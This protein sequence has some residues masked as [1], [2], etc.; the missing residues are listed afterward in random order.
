M[1]NFISNQMVSLVFTMEFKKVDKGKKPKFWSRYKIY[2]FIQSPKCKV[3]KNEGENA[4]Y[5]ERIKLVP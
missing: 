2:K 3:W 4:N 1:E 5:S